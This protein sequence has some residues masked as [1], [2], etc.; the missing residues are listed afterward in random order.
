[1]RAPLAPLL[2][3]IVAAAPAIPQAQPDTM[4]RVIGKAISARNGAPLSGVMVAVP[5]A[6]AFAVSDATGAF[7][8]AGLPAG[9][10]PLRV[11]YRDEVVDERPV[12]LRAGKTLRLE[13]LLDVE[14]VDLAPVVVEARSIRAAHSLAGFYDRRR[15][16]F[17]RFYTFEDLE[18]RG[19]ASLRA[20]LSEAGVQVQ[21][22]S[23]SCVAVSHSGPRACV[24]PVYRDGVPFPIMDDLDFV[25]L[26]ELA[27]V[28]VYK[29]GL[30]VPL[31]FQGGFVGGCGA[32]LIWTR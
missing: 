22:R 7:A 9:T 15:S 29:H 3:L 17:G 11:L 12:K 28:E 23:W 26:D 21:C 14:A 13:V 31:E 16:G 18:R 1:M 27:A 10:Q 24:L 19:S 6:K 30:E 25:R 2:I 8:L 32:I 20:L 4:A 5:Q